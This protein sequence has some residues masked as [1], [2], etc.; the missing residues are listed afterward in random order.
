MYESCARPEILCSGLKLAFTCESFKAFVFDLVSSELHHSLFPVS[1]WTPKTFSWFKCFDRQLC[2]LPDN[3]LKVESSLCLWSLKKPCTGNLSFVLRMLLDE[4]TT[5]HLSSFF[6]LNHSTCEI[7]LMLYSKQKVEKVVAPSGF[8][9]LLHL[10][11]AAW[12][13]YTVKTIVWGGCK[14]INV[15]STLVWNTFLFISYINN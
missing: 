15:L 8:H 9:F 2:C 11:R 7:L 13:C 4:N 6:A 14:S 10:V 12:V 5:L 1:H 3:N